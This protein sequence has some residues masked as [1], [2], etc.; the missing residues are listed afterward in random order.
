LCSLSDDI[1]FKLSQG[2]KDVK[3]KFSA[4]GGCVYTLGDAF[5]ADFSVVK[6]GD[7]FNEMLQRPA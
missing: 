2:A 7:G 4:T 1:P 3:D 5:K 6:V